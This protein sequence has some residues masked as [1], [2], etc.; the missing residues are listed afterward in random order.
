MFEGR[1][2]LSCH[3]YFVSAYHSKVSIASQR[4]PYS[5]IASACNVA[6][7]E[8][9]SPRARITEHIFSYYP[10]LCGDRILEFLFN[11]MAYF[12]GALNGDIHSFNYKKKRTTIDL[13]RARRF[14]FFFFFFFSHFPLFVP[15]SLIVHPLASVDIYPRG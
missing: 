13:R 12:C 3:I 1:G 14:L 9:K 6:G 11:I 4:L 10:T 8:S 2:F 7:S 5:G 15:L